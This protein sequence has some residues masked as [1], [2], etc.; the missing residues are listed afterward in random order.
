MRVPKGMPRYTWLSDAVT[1]GRKH[2]VVEVFQIERSSFEERTYFFR[3]VRATG[4]GPISKPEQL[5]AP[6]ASRCFGSTGRQRVTRAAAA[7]PAT[8]ENSFFDQVFHIPSRRVL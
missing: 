7:F 1:C 8:D 4:R 5:Q 2:A 3:H 6:T